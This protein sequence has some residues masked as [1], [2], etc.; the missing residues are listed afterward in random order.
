MIVLSDAPTCASKNR[1]RPQSATLD[2]RR[3]SPLVME[4][5]DERR[6]VG[7]DDWGREK[8]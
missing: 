2:A 5:A 3:G 4:R 8:L 1:S 6:E 7:M